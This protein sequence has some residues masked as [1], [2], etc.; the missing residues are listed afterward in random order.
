MLQK[1]IEAIVVYFHKRLDFLFT[2][3]FVCFA[4]ASPRAS[5]RRKC[6]RKIF[7]LVEKVLKRNVHAA[8]AFVSSDT[9]IVEGSEEEAH[10][11]VE[12]TDFLGFL[13][14]PTLYS[15]LETLATAPAGTPLAV[16]ADALVYGCASRLFAVV[17]VSSSAVEKMIKGVKYGIDPKQYL[18]ADALDAAGAAFCG[19]HSAPVAEDCSIFSGIRAKARAAMRGKK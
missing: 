14:D 7:P 10:E 18:N 15:A 16:E 9:P 13:S 5:E 17:Q 2:W 1:G 3:P 8:A 11:I 6:A 4:L 12:T 19:T